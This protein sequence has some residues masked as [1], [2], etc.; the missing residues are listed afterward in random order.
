MLVLKVGKMLYVPSYRIVFSF[1]FKVQGS[2]DL[3]FAWQVNSL[4]SKLK[5]ES[6]FASK[7]SLTAPP[8]SSVVTIV[9]VKTITCLWYSGCY[10]E[11]RLPLGEFP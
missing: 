8:P 4:A 10:F 3:I 6:T 2:P 1:L 5:P 7:Q 11:T 9:K